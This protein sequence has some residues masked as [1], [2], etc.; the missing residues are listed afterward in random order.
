[1]VVLQLTDLAAENLYGEYQS[2]GFG[3]TSLESVVQL[4]PCRSVTLLA[5]LVRRHSPRTIRHSAIENKEEIK[6]PALSV[7]LFKRLWNTNSKVPKGLELESFV[8]LIVDS[9]SFANEKAK[10]EERTKVTEL[11]QA[12]NSTVLAITARVDD[13]DGTSAD[14]TRDYLVAVI[15]Y[16]HEVPVG[17]LSRTSA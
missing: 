13:L 6:I 1:M 4:Y 15:V 11:L 2:H 3:R 5:M 12:E 9:F 14:D 8:E 16:F 17:C 7:I 10:V